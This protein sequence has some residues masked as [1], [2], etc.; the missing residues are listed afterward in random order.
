MY[1]IFGG[2]SKSNLLS[3]RQSNLSVNQFDILNAN[4]QLTTEMSTNT[5]LDIGNI[6]K[7]NSTGIHYSNSNPVNTS[8]QDSQQS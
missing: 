8:I 6:E 7:S 2:K 1:H 5:D 4:N 3:N